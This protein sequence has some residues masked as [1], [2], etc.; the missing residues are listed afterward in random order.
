MEASSQE[1]QDLR[2]EQY[3]RRVLFQ[4][5]Q[6][7]SKLRLVLRPPHGCGCRLFEP[8]GEGFRCLHC[9]PPLDF[10]QRLQMVVDATATTLTKHRADLEQQFQEAFARRCA[11]ESK[12][13]PKKNPLVRLSWTSP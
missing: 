13:E 1:T 7:Y 2:E 4:I 3:A 8:I 5:S 10:P 12:A 9:M 11:A 6:E